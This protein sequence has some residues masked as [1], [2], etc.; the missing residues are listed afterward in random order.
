M[1]SARGARWT[2]ALG[3]GG[4]RGLPE[5]SPAPNLASPPWPAGPGAVWDLPSPEKPLEEAGRVAVIAE[6]LGVQGEQRQICHCVD[7]SGKLHEAASWS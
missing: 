6:A 5:S 7:D 3:P 1:A 4:G 2:P